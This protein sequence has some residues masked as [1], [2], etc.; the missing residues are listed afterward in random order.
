MAKDDTTS[1]NGD[2]PTTW[3]ISFDSWGDRMGP[4]MQWQRAIN[5][6]NMH[7]MTA[8]M[9]DVIKEWDY[10]GIDPTDAADYENLDIDQFRRAMV[11]V[12]TARR[13]AFRDIVDGKEAAK[14]FKDAESK[15]KLG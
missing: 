2:S 8:I 9:T 11:Y 4:Q 15:I 14:M 13:M 3:R 5:L 6:E 1:A 7:N 10:A 12:E